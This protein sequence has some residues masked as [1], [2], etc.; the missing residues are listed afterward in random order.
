M[1]YGGLVEKIGQ[2]G[3]RP[4]RASTT[5]NVSKL[6]IPICYAV[7]TFFCWMM[8]TK[9]VKTLEDLRDHGLITKGSVYGH[10]ESSGKS[11]S[12][13]LD[14]LYIVD[15][16]SYTGSMKVGRDDY[17]YVGVGSPINITYLPSNPEEH[18]EGVVNDERVAKLKSNW[19]L[20]LAAITGVAAIAYGILLYVYRRQLNLL[21]NGYCVRAV[22]ESIRVHRG[23]NPYRELKISFSGVDGRSGGATITAPINAAWAMQEQAEL[24]YLY[25]ADAPS[26]GRIVMQLK[27]VDLA[28][29]PA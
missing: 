23:K 25:L 3:P 29:A 5:M 10:H 16:N 11:T 21:A 15:G 13:Y 8:M 20:G 1:N 2:S 24:P 27:L 18:R 7:L 28:P 26:S 6:A 22:I 14:Y 12:Y 4:A 9:Q 17:D 19:Q